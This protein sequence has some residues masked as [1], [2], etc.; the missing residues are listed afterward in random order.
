MSMGRKGGEMEGGKGQNKRVGE[1]ERKRRSDGI[2]E[3]ESL[4]EGR[5]KLRRKRCHKDM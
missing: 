2:S 5:Y 3:G 1:E 4:G